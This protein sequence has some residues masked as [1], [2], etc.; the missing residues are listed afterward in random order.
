MSNFRYSQKEA[1]PNK[2][3]TLM[4]GITLLL[5]LLVSIQIWLLYS[6]LNNALTE[7][8]KIAVSTFLGSLVLFITS[9]WLLRYLPEPRNPKIKE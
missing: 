1:H 4:T 9:A 5:I 8:F 2:T 6:A 3:N 7:N